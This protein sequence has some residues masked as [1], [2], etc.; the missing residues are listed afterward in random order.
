MNLFSADYQFVQIPGK[1]NIIK[2][3]HN[4][5]YKIAC[6]PSKDSDQP[7]HPHILS[8]ASVHLNMLIWVS[9]WQTCNFVRNAMLIEFYIQR[10]YE[11]RYR[12]IMK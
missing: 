8:R 9:A 3:G 1:L 6:A 4:I 2:T 10:H 12:G 11:I 5:F 7:V